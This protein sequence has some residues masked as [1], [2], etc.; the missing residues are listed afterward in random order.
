MSRRIVARSRSG[1]TA[2]AASRGV[3]K[4]ATRRAPTTTTGRRQ[5]PSSTLM[6]F[7][8]FWSAK[9]KGPS[10]SEREPAERVVAIG[11]S[12]GGLAA[13]SSV[14]A[15]LPGDVPAA[16]VVVLHLTPKHRSHLAEIFARRTSLSVL[17]AAD[18]DRLEAGN[19][20]VAP[21]N[22]HTIVRADGRL[23]LEG[24]PRIQHVRPSID[25]FFES[26]AEAY[27]GRAVAVVLSGTGKDGAE[28]VR[29]VKAAGGTV[30]AQSVETSEHS[31]MPEAAVATGAVDSVLPL[32]EIAAAI[33]DA[34]RVTEPA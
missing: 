17:E 1:A 5:L 29:Q 3:C 30:L 12:A 6:Y 21:P 2:P 32:T 8:R 34:V 33:V 22:A 7:G 26:L 23:A 4:T 18:G 15:D 16:F 25:R 27:G 13:T 28:G 20:Y 24:G 11:S 9:V 31:G 14:L 10:E 19:V